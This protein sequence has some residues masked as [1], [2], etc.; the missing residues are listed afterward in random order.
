[1]R[2]RTASEPGRYADG[3]GL[4]LVVDPSGARRWVLRTVVHGRR[5]D[6]GLGGAKLVGLAEARDLAVQYRKLARDGGDPLSLRRQTR[7]VVPTFEAAARAVHA[8]NRPTWRNAKHADQWIN[9]LV[10]YVFPLIGTRPVNQIAAP[11]LLT[12]LAPIWLTKP[13]TARRVRQRISTVLDWAKAAGHRTGDNPVAGLAKGLPKQPERSAHHAAI[14]YSAVPAFIE[15][16]RKSD[17]NETVRLAFEFLILTAART[18][19]VLG[20]KLPEIDLAGLIW[21]VPAERMK[22][23]RTHRVPL[24]PRAVAILDRARQLN[25]DSPYI[26]AGRKPDLP[27]S[28][29]AFLMAMRRMG[30][31]ATAHGFRSAF[32]DWASERTNFA[33]EL[34]ELALAHSIKSKVEAA[35]R[36]GDQLEKRRTLMETWAAFTASSSSKV[37]RLRA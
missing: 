23:G 24:A 35:Y 4:Y 11:D 22:G 14:P 28:N 18:S 17:S 20:A 2:V 29:M 8:D 36:R 34:C 16:L 7:Q 6:I 10:E 37:V 19:E 5:R 31:D 9:T 3:N 27:L 25:P 13:E 1:M 26:F 32:R 15:R 12:V 33:N 21:T 30:V